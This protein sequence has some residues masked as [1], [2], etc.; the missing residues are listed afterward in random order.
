LQNEIQAIYPANSLQ[1]GFIYHALSQPTDD[2]YR[3]QTFFDYSCSIN[4]NFYRQ[5]WLLAVKTYPSLRTCFNW[6]EQPLQIVTKQGQLQFIEKDVTTEIDKETAILNIQKADR[7][8]SFDLTK[9]TLLRLCLIKKDESHYTL[10]KTEHHSIADAWSAAILLH[11][12]HRYYELL[13]TGGVPVIAEDGAYL[14]AQ[15]YIAKNQAKAQQHWQ[16]VIQSITQ[17]N[18]VNALFTKRVDLD[19]LKSVTVPGELNMLVSQDTYQALQYICQSEGFTLYSF[20]QFAWH[21]LLQIYTQDLQTVVGTT[22][23][24]RTIPVLC[25]EKS[26][27]LY[28]NTLPLIIDWDNDYSVKQQ[29]NLLH[30]KIMGMNDFS[31]VHLSSLQTMGKRLFHT[32]LLFENQSIASTKPNEYLTAHNR[33]GVQKLD[34]PLVLTVSGRNNTFNL[35]LKYDGMYLSASKAQEILTQFMCILDQ[36]P[37]QL[38]L[39]HQAIT[40][41]NKTDFEKI[42]YQWNETVFPYPQDKTLHEIFS[43][44]AKRTPERIALIVSEER[45]TYKELDTRSNQLAAMLS[46]HASASRLIALCLDRSFELL[47]GILGV[48]KSGCGYVPLDPNHPDAWMRHVLQDTAAT[49]M[50]TERDKAQRFEIFESLNVFALDDMPYQKFSSDSPVITVKPTDVAYVMYTSGT[51]GQAKGVVI[52]HRGVVNRIAWMQRTY[53]LQATDVVLHKTPYGFD[54]SVWELLW[55]HWTGA[56]LVMAKPDGHKDPTYLQDLMMKH[57]INVVHFVPSMLSAYTDMLRTMGQQIPMSLRHVFCSGE[58]LSQQQVE[59]FYA[60][61]TTQVKLHNL[62]GPTEASIDVTA[63][64]CERGAETVYLGRPIQNIKVYVLDASLKLLPIGVIGELYL[65]G[66]GLADGYLNQPELTSRNFLTN[67][68]TNED[69]HIEGYATLYKTGDFVR[70][71]MD[72]YLEYVGRHDRQVKIRGQRVELKEI[73]NVLLRYPGVNEAAVIMNHDAGFLAGYYVSQ[74]VNE[75]ALLS[76]LKENLP[77][78]MVPAILIAQTAFPVTVNGKLDRSALPIP[79]WIPEKNVY[80]APNTQFELLLCEAWQTVL[81]I[82]RVGITDDFFSLGGDS[83]R[84]IRLVVAMQ[85]LGMHVTVHDMFL[86]KTIRNLLNNTEYETLLPKIT[87]TPYELVN[88]STFTEI[89]NQYNENTI[90]DI[91]PASYLQMEMLR[92]SEQHA[93]GLYHDVFAYSIKDVFNEERLLAVFQQ[94]TVQYP[95]LRTA[96]EVHVSYGYV[97]IQYVHTPIRDHYLDVESMNVEEFIRAEKQQVLPLSQPGLFRLKILNPSATEF[98]LVFSFHHAMTDGWSV[99]SLMAVFISAYTSNGIVNHEII[100]AYQLVIKHEQEALRTPMYRAFWEKY[101]KNT[102]IHTDQLK[103]QGPQLQLKSDAFFEY[104]CRISSTLSSSVLSLAKHVTV[105]PDTIFLAAYLRTLARLFNQ[106]DLVIGLVVNNRLEEAGGDKV[107]G[108]HLNIIPFRAQLNQL[109]EHTDFILTLAAEKMKLAQ[110]KA[111][112]SS[113]LPSDLNISTRLYTCV[114]NYIHFHVMENKNQTSVITTT[115][116]FEKMNIPLTL[117]VLR[118]HKNTFEL[119]IRV[120]DQ[121]IDVDTVQKILDNIQLELQSITA[122]SLAYS[123]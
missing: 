51:T 104:G 33:R 96:F 106:D 117:Q 109:L 86:H 15:A 93:D 88:N 56:T 52:P 79:Q 41:L 29:L 47:I 110:Y 6:E 72:G 14:Q 67:H 66:V 95:L 73:E 22:L 111:Y 113:K 49:V 60:L 13:I 74:D 105:S 91:Y 83:I 107:F 103:L 19:K 44:Q 25:I 90:E 84:S 119:T 4:V 42:I 12:V 2:A 35:N 122:P 40:L 37:N 36:L 94:L 68:F 39:S 1:L 63:F 58:A 8:I 99:A 32:L 27:G 98:T 30:T 64:T 57:Q 87:Y 38:H 101:L 50:L 123:T 69:E 61:S 65:S 80:E 23:S 48:L 24:G 45:L 9:P 85:K 115:H 114:F 59:S 53:P 10:L 46:N 34:Y 121:F 108:L 75:T 26:V 112:P 3:V 102:V 5:A 21:K 55:A 7:L 16:A 82:P 17:C 43:E 100:P 71:T 18:D 28:I 92:E 54:V 62:Y 89:V 11:Q 97:A 77:S 20:I 31:F 118:T 78:Y 120:V 76:F 70:W 116:A 81:D